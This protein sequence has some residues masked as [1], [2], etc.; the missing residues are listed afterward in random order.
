VTLNTSPL[1]VIYHLLACIW[2]DQSHY[3]IKGS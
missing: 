2:Y 1:G 3:Q